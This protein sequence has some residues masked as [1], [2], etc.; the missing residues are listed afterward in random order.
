MEE[1]SLQ[2]AQILH[3]ALAWTVRVDSISYNVVFD[4]ISDR[5]LEVKRGQASD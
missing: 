5:D 1:F 4:S 3:R 2:V